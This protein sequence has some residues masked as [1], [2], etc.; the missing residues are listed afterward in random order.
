MSFRQG[1]P[2]L[3]SPMDQPR[4]FEMIQ[5]RRRKNKRAGLV[6]YEASYAQKRLVDIGV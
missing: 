4:I 2:V 3:D 1:A 5:L 6:S